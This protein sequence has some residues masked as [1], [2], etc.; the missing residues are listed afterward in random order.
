[1]PLGVSFLAHS[2]PVYCRLQK[3]LPLTQVPPTV[4]DSLQERVLQMRALSGQGPTI[5]FRKEL[6]MTCEG[7]PGTR[8][9]GQDSRQG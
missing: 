6:G 4:Q 1:L 2:G 7:G 8:A 5:P 3:H 9:G